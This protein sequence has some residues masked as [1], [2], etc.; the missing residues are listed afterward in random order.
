[1]DLHWR[2]ALR[3]PKWAAIYAAA[4]AQ[5][6]TPQSPLHAGGA[7]LCPAL[8]YT[9]NLVFFQFPKNILKKL[10]WVKYSPYICLVIGSNRHFT[11]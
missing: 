11:V 4:L 8:T 5:N 2:K 9:L 10:A 3:R 6:L 1:M 7:F